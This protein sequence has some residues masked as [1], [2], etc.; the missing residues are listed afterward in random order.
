MERVGVSTLA[1]LY[2]MGHERHALLAADRKDDVR[3]APLKQGAF[4]R[5]TR[6]GDK[7]R[8]LMD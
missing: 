7:D 8:H 6:A 4:F 5:D 2:R 3:L 1:Q